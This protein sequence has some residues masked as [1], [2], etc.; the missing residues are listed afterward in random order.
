MVGES[1]GRRRPPEDPALTATL[2]AW[3]RWATAA[4]ATY[5]DSPDDVPAGL[6]LPRWSWDGPVD[7]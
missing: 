3:F 1:V 6:S 7:G 4:M 5:P 2:L